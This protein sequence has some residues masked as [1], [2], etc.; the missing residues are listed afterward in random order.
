MNTWCSN[1]RKQIISWLRGFSVPT[2]LLVSLRVLC[3]V[4]WLYSLLPLNS[5]KIHAPCPNWLCVLLF[6]PIKFNCCCPYMC[7]LPLNCDQHTRATFLKTSLCQKLAS[8]PNSSP[9]RDENPWPPYS[10]CFDLGWFELAGMCMLSR[11]LR[12]RMCSC[13]LECWGHYFLVFVQGFLFWSFVSVYFYYW[14]CLSLEIFL[15]LSEA[16]SLIFLAYAVIFKSWLFNVQ[17]EKK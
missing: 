15:G 13:G 7:G 6:P 4:F 5:F 14:D 12:L 17:K 8:V 10:P 2:F 3:Y 9:A 11:P 1:S 16:F